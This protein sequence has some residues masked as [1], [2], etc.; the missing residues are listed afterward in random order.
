MAQRIY[1]LVVLFFFSCDQT[2]TSYKPKSSGNI[3]TV[4]VVVE[5]KVWNS[6]LGD[7]LREVFASEFE[8]LPQQEPLFTLVHI[9][10]KI[11]KD[12]AREGR[13]IIKISPK[14]VDTA[15]IEKNKYA[16]PQLVL[17]I[18][19]PNTKTITKQLNKISSKAILAFRNN[20]V[21][22]KQRRIRKS[23]LKT[24]EFK[25]LG[26][27]LTLPS[28]Y[29]LFKKDDQNKL[30]FQRETKK[31]S[32]NFL[33]YTLPIISQPITLEKVIKI[34]DSI[35]KDF[36]PGRNEDSYVITEKAYEPYFNKVKIKN[37]TAFKTKGTWEVVNDYMA[38]PFLNIIIEDAKNQRYVV[39]EGFVFSPSDRKR[40]YMV[41]IEA[42]IKSLKIL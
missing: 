37:L 10:P 11:F 18:E 29:S 16:S 34:R 6:K 28:A 30:W 27:N 40:E 17:N 5:D 42:I 26:I 13:N 35:G 14:T 33:T 2:T 9:P 39:F 41:E 24:E 7:N 20:E 15:Y 32:V 38:G 4:S 1:I 8:G 3:K 22:E 25:A 31:G 36:V 21:I 12:F 23:V 19:G